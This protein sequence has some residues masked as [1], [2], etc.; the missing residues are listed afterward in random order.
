M[1]FSE[2]GSLLLS[3]PENQKGVVN[4]GIINSPQTCVLPPPALFVPGLLW[5]WELGRVSGGGRD[6]LQSD[7]EMEP[8]ALASELLL[9]PSCSLG[10][11]L[12][13]VHLTGGG[14]SSEGGLWWLRFHSRFSAPLSN[15]PVLTPSLLSDPLPPPH[16]PPL[17][18]LARNHYSWMVPHRFSSPEPGYSLTVTHWRYLLVKRL[19]WCLLK[20]LVVF[21]MH[22]I[23]LILTKLSVPQVC[24]VSIGFLEVFKNIIVPYFYWS[25]FRG[26][27]SGWRKG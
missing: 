9:A 12:F 10:L 13:T 25:S 22:P 5:C 20:I 3:I 26:L 11:G 6:A 2:K 7:G 16:R 27:Y 18:F 21:Q 17:S 4:I 19:V 15:G 1:R 24:S 8:S 23:I 14:M